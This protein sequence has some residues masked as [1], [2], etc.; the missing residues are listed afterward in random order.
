[1]VVGMAL[2][3][4]SRALAEGGHEDW[5]DAG[6]RLGSGHVSV[7][8]QEYHRQRTIEHRL[9]DEDRQ[10]VETALAE[11]DIARRL[12]AVAPRLAVQ[13][14]ASSAASA[15]PVAVTGVD[16]EAEQGFSLLP[17]RLEAGRYLEPGDRLHAYVGARLA[18][19]LDLEPGDRF[20]LTA[21]DESGE[22]VGQ[23]ARVVGTFRTGI[24][25]ADEALV[26]IPL[27]T[28]QEWLGVP[29]AVT[30]VDL[31]LESSRAV[32]PV[33]SSLETVL[34]EGSGSI[35]PLDWRVAQPELDAA[36]RMDDW[37]DYV[38][39]VILFGIA[40]LAIIN[41]ILMSVMQRTREFGVLRALG[42][43]RAEVG[44][45]VFTEGMLL[46]IV[47]GLAGML[48]GVAVVWLFFRDGLDFS[49]LM[50]TDMTAAGV[51]ID[52]VIVPRFHPTQIAQSL[53]FILA[54]GILAS[55][56]PAWQATRIDVAEAM[57][58]SE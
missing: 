57:K 34:G 32:R 29:G 20:V 35:V 46:T 26:Q 31:L 30:S 45:L 25:E 42:L 3:V 54:V 17:D 14:L 52:P 37:A 58:F 41:T 8:A 16:P 2:L 33:L 51:V 24:P 44:Q 28:A 39:H 36:V 7:Q 56:Y 43:R 19:R 9:S 13:G 38:F 49:A 21:Q 50:N 6:V 5:I 47:S 48:L 22:I 23:M 40:A 1:M 4:F 11:P 53:F 27:P 10:A 18:E 12:V 15:L 55:I